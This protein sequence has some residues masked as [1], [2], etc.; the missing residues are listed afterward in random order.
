VIRE[1]F[2]ADWYF[3][4][5]P[6][7]ANPIKTGP[8]IL[9]HDAMLLEKRDPEVAN[10]YNTGYFP[11][12]VYH[13]SKAFTLPNNFKEKNIIFE[14]EGVYMN[15]EVYINGQYAGGRPYGY[16]NFYIFAENLLKESIE[17]LID[18]VVHNDEEPNSRWYSGSGIYRNVKIMIANRLHIAQDGVKITTREVQPHLADIAVLTRLINNHDETKRIVLRIELSGMDGNIVASGEEEVLLNAGE[19]TTVTKSIEVEEPKLWSVVEP[20]LYTCSTRIFDGGV[21]ADEDIET[22]GIRTVEL[23]ATHGLR[24]NG[25]GIKLRGGCIHHDNGLVGACALEGAEERRVRILKASGFNAIRSAHNP[26]SK[27]MLEACDRYGMLVMDEFAD[28]WLRSKTRHDYSR[29]FT[30]WWER[31]IQ[32][33]VDKDYNHPCVIIYSIGNEIA[34]TAIPEGVKYSRKL[35]EKIKSLDSSRFV[36]NSINGWLSYFTVTQERLSRIKKPVTFNAALSDNQDKNIGAMITPFMMLINKFMDRIVSLPGIDR[37]TREAYATVDIAGYN[38]M[39]G[40]YEKDGRKYPGRVIC[41]SET[42]PADIAKNWRLVKKLPY[43]IGDF[44]WT[45]WD[46]LGEAGLCTWQYGGKN[47][48]FKPF[49][50]IL[51][52]SA[53][54]DITGHRQTQSYVHE[55]AWGLRKD[56]FIAVQPI[57]HAGQKHSKSLW[58]SSNAIDSWTWHG[59]EGS[60]AVIEVYADAYQVELLVNGRS[61]GKKPAGD[62]QDFKAVY[63]TIY[64]PGELTAVSYDKNGDEIG[65]QTLKTGSRQLQL[66]LQPES[67]TLKADGAALSYIS[68]LIGDESGIVNPLADRMVTVQVEGPG[69]LQGF[70]SANPFTE[71]SFMDNTHTSYLGR[72]V[73]V[74]RA[75]SE[76]GNVRVSVSAD[77]CDTKSVMLKVEP[78]EILID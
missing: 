23:D 6:G 52:D 27:G 39:T 60:K 28:I 4:K 49:P 11:G 56:P 73:A 12:G 59:Y 41:G 1:S 75:G 22:F 67:P 50:C 64:V 71:E 61:L 5:E 42:F 25:E 63:R 77:G 3:Y 69:T 31:D 68:I 16:S 57:N 65:R 58:R 44:S 35:V 9:P 54:I 18:V 70:G 19:T 78:V 21:V 10:S 29:F 62:K 20:N 8:I 40:R 76:S 26:L 72:A 37:C 45:A 2:N 47:S 48:L 55:I 15:C 24:I 46:Y 51:A 38:Y 17:N 43:L 7:P 53:M 34:E 14:F 36:I 30:E 13:Y 66:H 32:A 33:M 74:I